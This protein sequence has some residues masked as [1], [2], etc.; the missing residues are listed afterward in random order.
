MGG[1]RRG[2]RRDE[3]EGANMMGGATREQE[4]KE[5]VS[6]KTSM[7][8]RGSP[9]NLLLLLLDLLVVIIVLAVSMGAGCSMSRASGV[10]LG[11]VWGAS[12][13]QV[14]VK[15]P[16]PLEYASMMKYARCTVP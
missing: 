6:R 9:H 5:G 10:F 7:K 15:L 1:R 14:N 11:G 4:G 8:R 13:L 3:G 12:M 2:C 16:A